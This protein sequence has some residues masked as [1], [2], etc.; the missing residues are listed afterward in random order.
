MHLTKHL[1]VLF[2]IPTLFFAQDTILPKVDI[3][4]TIKPKIEELIF[5]PVILKSDTLFYLKSST[6]NYPVELRAK[7]LS[8]RLKKLTSNYNSFED[9]LTVVS[10]KDFVVVKYNNEIAFVVT[11]NDAKNSDLPILELAELRKNSFLTSLNSIES[12]A[13]EEWLKR[14]G[15]FAISLIVLIGLLKLINWLFKKLNVPL[16]KIEKNFLKKNRNVIKYFIPKKTANIFVFLSNIIRIGLIALLL[17]VYAP[18]MFSFFPF[19]EHIV[20]LFY[21]YIST[22]IKYIFFGFINFLPSLFFIIIIAFVARYIVRVIHDIAIDVELGKFIIPNFHKD[23]AQP[24]GKMVSVFI[25]AFALVLIF[26]YLPGSGSTAFQGVSIFIGAIISFGS[27]SAIANIIA[28][29]VITYMRPFQIGD[30]VKIDNIIGDVIS[31][32]TLVTKVR[33]TKNEDVTIPN[34]N[35]LIGNIINFSSNNENSIILHTTVT[36]GYDLPWQ[37]AEKLLIEAANK[38]QFVD[39]KPSPFV[40]QISLDDYYVSYELNIYTKESKRIPFIYSEVHKNILDVF[41]EAGVEILS[42]AYMAAR[43]GSLT[44]VPSEL[45]STDKSPINKLVD[46]LTGQNQKITITKST[47]N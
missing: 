29:I 25:Y 5:A 23:W 46:H 45:K 14:I 39:K 16:S 1:L 36:L 27:T 24:T 35:I 47:D 40:L 43:D 31:K 22:P 32:T 42:P 30:R 17:F 12:L 21:G 9:G 6:N 4:T 41:N 34:A 15:Y 2:F 18:F 33:T 37:T 26:P 19:A 10:K 7:E 20:E 3:E 38:T 13:T 11:N 44:T 8:N 28:G